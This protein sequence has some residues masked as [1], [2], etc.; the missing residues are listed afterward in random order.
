MHQ[1]NSLIFKT[2]IMI[3]ACNTSSGK[4]EKQYYL[5][6]VNACEKAKIYYTK[7]KFCYFILGTCVNLVLTFLSI[8]YD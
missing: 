8:A 6:N 2:V 3:P 1:C 7:S 4:K 5:L